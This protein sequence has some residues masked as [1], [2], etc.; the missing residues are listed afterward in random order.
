M[1]SC[2][3]A[4][5]GW[6][7]PTFSCGHDSGT[8]EADGLHC[9]SCLSF[10]DAVTGHSFFSVPYPYHCHLLQGV[11]LICCSSAVAFLSTLHNH[12]IVSYLC[13]RRQWKKVWT[14]TLAIHFTSICL[15]KSSFFLTYLY[16]SQ[17]E[18]SCHLGIAYFLSSS[19]FMQ[20]SFFRINKESL[21]GLE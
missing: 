14:F 8:W 5:Q 15:Q 13:L 17:N 10:M 19:W 2:R 16:L 1:F 7:L 11:T 4:Q 21:G 3:G 9:S 18:T 6:R 20:A 12:C